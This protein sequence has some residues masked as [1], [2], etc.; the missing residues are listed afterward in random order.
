MKRA[1]V[2]L[3]MFLCLPAAMAAANDVLSEGAIK[4]TRLAPTCPKTI[5]GRWQY[6]SRNTDTLYG[7]IFE[8]RRTSVFFGLL[9]EFGFTHRFDSEGREYFALNRPLVHRGELYG[10]K[11]R[12]LEID[13]PDTGSFV[14]CMLRLNLCESEQQTY[15]LLA[16][17]DNYCASSTY[18]PENPYKHM[19]HR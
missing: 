3:L 1:L 8:V 2:L 7:E 17:K 12:F 10:T 16:G 15:D 4:D 13:Y 14:D 19:N 5:F 9:G 18:V 11:Y 6:L